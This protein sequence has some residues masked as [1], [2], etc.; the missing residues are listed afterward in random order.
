MLLAHFTGKCYPKI[1]KNDFKID[2]TEEQF[3][4]QRLNYPNYHHLKTWDSLRKRIVII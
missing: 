4:F 3:M 1:E 2:L